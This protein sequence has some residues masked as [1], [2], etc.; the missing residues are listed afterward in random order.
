MLTRACSSATQNGTLAMLVYA[1]MQ[2]MM[3]LNKVYTRIFIHIN[4]I[5]LM[6]IQK[7]EHIY[8]CIFIHENYIQLMGIQK[9]DTYTI[10]IYI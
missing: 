1:S 4:F 5:Q 6:G 3:S 10:I 9:H 7:H 8:T 2:F